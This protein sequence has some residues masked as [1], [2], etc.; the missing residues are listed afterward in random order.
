MIQGLG[1]YVL[2]PISW[3]YELAKDWIDGRQ[4]LNWKKKG[5]KTQTLS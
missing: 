5:K 1:I 2:G 4:G 3:V